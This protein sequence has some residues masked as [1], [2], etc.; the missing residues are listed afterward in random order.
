MQGYN[1]NGCTGKSVRC[2]KCKN[3]VH[4]KSFPVELCSSCA[5]YQMNCMKCGDKIT[6]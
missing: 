3:H 5:E 1:C 2:T 4:M 6:K